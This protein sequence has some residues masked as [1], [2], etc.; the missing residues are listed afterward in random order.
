MSNEAPVF[1]AACTSG[2]RADQSHGVL[3]KLMTV[4]CGA[5]GLIL[6][7]GHRLCHGAALGDRHHC[8]QL[9]LFSSDFTFL[10]ECVR[11]DIFNNISHR[12]LT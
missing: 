4:S 6:S 1:R 5:L 2:Q 9:M 11:N 12:T 10:E 8:F 7:P 3:G